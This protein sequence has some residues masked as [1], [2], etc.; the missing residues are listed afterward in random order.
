MVDGR[1][2]FRLLAGVTGQRMEATDL[3][4]RR[5]GVD[6]SRANLVLSMLSLSSSSRIVTM[7]LGIGV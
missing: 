4:K 6:K 3:H 7:H 5:A 2:L 1:L